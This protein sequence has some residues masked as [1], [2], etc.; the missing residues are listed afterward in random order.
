MSQRV[1][2]GRVVCVDLA[3]SAQKRDQA[4][5]ADRPNYLEPLPRS[6]EDDC[7]IDDNWRDEIDHLAHTKVEDGEAVDANERR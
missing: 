2:C 7:P 1:G 4:Q 3:R 6:D 5:T